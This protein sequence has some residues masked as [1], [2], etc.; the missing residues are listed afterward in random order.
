MKW[1]VRKKF[2]LCILAVLAATLLC[3]L[4]K[5]GDQTYGFII[6][7][8][9]GAFVAGDLFEKKMLVN[10]PGNIPE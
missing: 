1:E 2:A 8:V 9:V 7:S 5:V 6:V 10:S 3:G 4:G